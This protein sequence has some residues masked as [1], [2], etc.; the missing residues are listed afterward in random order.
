VPRFERA[1]RAVLGAVG[2]SFV[3][4]CADV[5]GVAFAWSGMIVPPHWLREAAGLDPPQQGPGPDP[6]P[7]ASPDAGGGADATPAASTLA[8]ATPLDHPE[9]V[10]PS[11]P[12]T[13]AE[14]RL[15]AQLEL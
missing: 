13:A 1:A 8:P 7:G 5:G 9:R 12:M 4:F 14:R 3:R 10:D 6:S 11:A 2:R 15:W